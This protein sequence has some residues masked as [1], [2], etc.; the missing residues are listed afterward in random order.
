MSYL[1][2][3]IPLSDLNSARM[4]SKAML[5]KKLNSNGSELYASSVNK[6]DDRLSIDKENVD[7]ECMNVT[8]IAEHIEC[9][10]LSDR[11]DVDVYGVCDATDV[12]LCSVMKQR[13]TF[14]LAAEV[15]Q[16]PAMLPSLQSDSIDVVN[17]I[18]EVADMYH[19]ADGNSDDISTQEIKA[20]EDK[21]D[22]FKQQH[23]AGSMVQVS[24]HIDSNAGDM[25]HADISEHTESTVELAS[26]TV[27]VTQVSQHIDRSAGDM[28]HADISEHT[29]SAVELASP[30][31]TVTQ[32]SQHTD[33]S[34]GDMYHADIS[35]RTQSAVELA[36]PTV[37][38]VACTATGSHLSPSVSVQ[39]NDVATVSLMLHRY[40]SSA[41]PSNTALSLCKDD[42]E[43]EYMFPAAAAP[44]HL[45]ATS[46][47]SS[48]TSVLAD[49]SN[50]SEAHDD[51][52]LSS[53]T[54]DV[55][56]ETGE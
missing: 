54:S 1:A 36:S 46:Q 55:D 28:H 18:G 10:L 7:V 39:T 53:D 31:V 43:Q 9:D 51:N 19:I 16:C 56:S 12:K 21:F 47:S 42:H 35:E 38:A 11:H 24:Q 4:D 41:L 20:H 15:V 44:S 37:T 5:F 25:H 52:M 13:K 23:R 17:L 14:S 48:A 45:S 22:D 34:A 30:I 40:N 27:T 32:V 50:T 29:E 33:S 2:R 3:I 6:V 8:H 26:P 49:T